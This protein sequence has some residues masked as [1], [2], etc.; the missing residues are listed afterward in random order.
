MSEPATWQICG[1]RLLPGERL[2]R[3]VS[4]DGAEAT[5]CE[6]C[7]GRAESAGWV[8]EHEATAL[9]ERGE[10]RQRRRAR[11]PLLGGLLTRSAPRQAG[12]A[13]QDEGARAEPRRAPRRSR[14]EREPAD[15]AQPPAE[16]DS[17]LPERRTER[18]PAR[19][20][21]PAVAP[22]TTLKEAITAFNESENRRTIAGLM[23]PARASGLAIRTSEGAPGARL[24]IAW[25]LAWYQWEVGPGGRGPEVRQSAK[26][27]TMD[28][29]R[30]ADRAW[31]LQVAEDGSLAQ[32][33]A[34]SDAPGSGREQ[35][36]G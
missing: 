2:L 35:S 13:E 26:G 22:G 23:G 3:Y 31:N 9:R 7:K 24:T 1:R 5:V 4:Q 18:P 32:R 14:P 28:Q 19:P 29:L 10:S 20:S 21:P 30:A 6:L 11:G 33:S 25:E 15:E 17:K 36:R 27:E 34:R 16:P 8:P 12:A